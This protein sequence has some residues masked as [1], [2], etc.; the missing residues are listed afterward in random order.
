MVGPLDFLDRGVDDH[1]AIG[2]HRHAVAD[3]VQRVQVVRDEEHGQPERLLQGPHQLVECVRADRVQSRGRLVEEQQRRVQCQR[4]RQ[5]GALAHAA[6]KFGRQLVD[7][8]RRET[9][10][11]HLQQRQFVAQR[12]G[13]VGVVL[14][15]R[16]LDVLADRERGEQRPILEQHAG[17]PLDVVPVLGLLAARIHAQ[18]LD[19]PGVRPAQADDRTHQHRLAAART[20]HNAEHLA[21]AHVEVQAFVHDLLAEAV[22]EPAHADGDVVVGHGQ[23]SM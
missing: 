12:I 8:V 4:A 22:L 14:L 17:P 15:E 11:L 16:H 13:Q 7:R 23:R 18:H 19:F 20:T 3:G 21:A 2:E 5:A 6:G 9:G 10:E 1:L